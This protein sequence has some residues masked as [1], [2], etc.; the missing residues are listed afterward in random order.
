MTPFSRRLLVEV[1]A[2]GPI[3]ARALAHRLGVGHGIV[4]RHVNALWRGGYVRRVADT[5][6]GWQIAACPLAHKELSIR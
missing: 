4:A 2:R 5:T 3:T 6:Q 1:V